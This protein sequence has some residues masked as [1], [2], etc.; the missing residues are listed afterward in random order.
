MIYSTT[1]ALLCFYFV[2][3]MHSMFG[4]TCVGLKS[5]N[6]TALA[7]ACESRDTAKCVRNQCWR[8]RNNVL[9]SCLVC[10]LLYTT[11]GSPASAFGI[12]KAL[13]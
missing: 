7:E 4:I 6:E 11:L 2:Y 12:M 3:Q 10:L 13:L 1:P 9:T 8:R 5:G